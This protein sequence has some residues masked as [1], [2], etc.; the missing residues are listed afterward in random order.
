[1]SSYL[2]Y[3]KTY[4]KA[5]KKIDMSGRKWRLIKV[6]M[7]VLTGLFVLPPVASF[8]MQLCG[9]NV[10]LVLLPASLYLIAIGA[11]VFMFM[12]ANVAQKKLTGKGKVRPDILD[13]RE[14]T[15]LD[16]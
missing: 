14:D 8:I 5:C 9:Y 12:L 15:E 16:A 13:S 10:E 4:V 7:V 1:M 3:I 2:E 11:L 6:L